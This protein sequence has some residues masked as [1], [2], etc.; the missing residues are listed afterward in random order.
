MVRHFERLVAT[1]ICA[2]KDDDILDG[3]FLM[4][5]NRWAIDIV[6]MHFGVVYKLVKLERLLSIQ[7][8]VSKFQCC[9]FFILDDA[10]MH[11]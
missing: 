4:D 8:N 6:T 9:N 1:R 3:S 10:K 7:L 11:G 5:D 2:A